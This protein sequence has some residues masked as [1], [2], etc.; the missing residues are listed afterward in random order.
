VTV[1]AALGSALLAL[2]LFV[3]IGVGRL[4]S[5]LK[6]TNRRLAATD[7]RV[8][9]IGEGVDPLAKSVASELRRIVPRVKGIS[10]DVDAVARDSLPAVQA[11]TR[12]IAAA[13]IP[14]ADEES[15][16]NLPEFTQRSTGSRAH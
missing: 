10:R 6:D 16:A 9:A 5:T 12:D 14:L 15:A 4:N 11:D 2:L 1:A 8:D 7:Q 13:V 3:L